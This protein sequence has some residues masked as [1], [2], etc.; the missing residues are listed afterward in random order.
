MPPGSALIYT[1]SNVARLPL[2]NGVDYSA[3]KAAIVSIVRSLSGQLAPLGIRVNAV[4]PGF[5]YTPFIAT[6]GYNTT[7]MFGVVRNF[8]TPRLE[9][10]AEL[11][12]M[13]VDLATADKTYVSGTIVGVTGGLQ[14]F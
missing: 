1:A 2:I 14:G 11:A 5:T 9:Q 4:A 12:P 6:G 7:T 8:P 10:P 13:Y 3:S